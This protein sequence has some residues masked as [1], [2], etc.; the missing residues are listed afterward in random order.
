MR[1]GAGGHRLGGTAT[2]RL[3]RLMFPRS[4]RTSGAAAGGA[5]LDSRRGGIGRAIQRCRPARW[6]PGTGTLTSA[7]SIP[8]NRLAGLRMTIEHSDLSAKIHD[9]SAHRGSPRARWPSQDERRPACTGAKIACTC[10][11]TVCT[12]E[13]AC[14]HARN[15]GVLAVDCRHAV[16]DGRLHHAT[17]FFHYGRRPLA[18]GAA[19][20]ARLRSAR[21]ARATAQL[22]P[23]TKVTR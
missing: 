9:L 2:R 15:G 4:A 5:P 17:R 7:G 8:Q 6:P 18:R 14:S 13:T 21:A 23:G 19:G 10:E 22:R 16:A 1:K 20:C 11:M 3:S 12:C